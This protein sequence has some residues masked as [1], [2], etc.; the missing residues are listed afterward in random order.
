MSEN[1][2]AGQSYNAAYENPGA[3]HEGRSARA[4]LNL[5]IK[6][7]G[8]GLTTSGSNLLHRLTSNGTRL[9]VNVG[10]IIG[11]S[12]ID[13]LVI[14]KRI[15]REV[16]HRLSEIVVLNFSEKRFVANAQ[17]LGCLHLIAVAGSERL[18]NLLTFN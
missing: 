14:G 12:L 7:Y 5:R 16:T 8:R 15:F 18:K 17:I 9:V 10:F 13:R 1:S 4:P 3:N 2:L 6:I 11:E